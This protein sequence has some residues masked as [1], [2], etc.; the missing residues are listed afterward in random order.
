MT[1]VMSIWQASWASALADAQQKNDAPIEQWRTAGRKTKDKPNGEDLNWWHQAGL[2]QV[3]AYRSWLEMSGWRVVSIDGK[4]LIEYEV[5][6]AFNGGET[7]VKGFI[8]AVMVTP[9]GELVIV[10]YKTGSRVPAGVQQ[11]AL[12][13]TMMGMVG[14]P[15]P[16][17][18]AWYM[19]RK[20]ELS[21]IEDLSRWDKAYFENLFAQLARARNADVYL[22]HISDMCGS[23]GVNSFCYAYGGSE[24]HLYDPLDPNF[25]KTD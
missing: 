24:S 14:L 13:A 16:T 19:T 21:P 18:G 7:P 8:D 4:P 5:N 20:G 12:Y 2:E 17:M 10:D 3:I 11:L 22:P 25:K 23:C 9:N 15:T 6:A 1:E